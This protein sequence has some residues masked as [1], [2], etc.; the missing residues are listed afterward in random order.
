[1][2]KSTSPH[3]CLWEKPGSALRQP[4][5]EVKMIEDVPGDAREEAGCFCPSSSLS[6]GPDIYH[7]RQAGWSD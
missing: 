7:A 1:M 3:S 2:L 5:D 4:A 6:A